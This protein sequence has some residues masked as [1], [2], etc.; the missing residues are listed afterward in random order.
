[1]G[2]SVKNSQFITIFLLHSG[3]YKIR[4]GMTVL[5]WISI[6]IIP[7]RVNSNNVNIQNDI[8]SGIYKTNVAIPSINNL[9]Y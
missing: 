3:L 9:S 1:M 8:P 2:W 4:I 6:Q 5:K 7:P